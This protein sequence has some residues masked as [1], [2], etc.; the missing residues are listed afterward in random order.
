VPL[1][2]LDGDVNVLGTLSP[3]TFT[4]PINSVTDTSVV[5][6][7]ALSA[8]KLQHQHQKV[9]VL[10]DHATNA[11][12][13]RVQ[14]HKVYGTTGTIL[15]FGVVAS[16]AAGAATTITV[17]LKKNGSSILSATITLD[18]GTAAYAL[19]QP[20]GFTSTSLVVTDILEADITAVSG[21]NLPKGVSCHLVLRE[22]AA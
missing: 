14:I 6:G 21:A 18:N 7:A 19:K 22:D 9:A 15:Q 20:A 3:R 12:V 8:S 4:L 11:A 1:T 13:K 16:V 10:C 17:D 5:A 2:I